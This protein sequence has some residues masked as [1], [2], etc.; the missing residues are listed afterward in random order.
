LGDLAQPLLLLSP[1]QR[2]TSTMS[3]TLD[4]ATEDRI[5]RELARGSYREPAEV[6]SRALD[7]L[8]ANREELDN[9]RIALLVRIE[10]SFAQ[11]DRGETYSS[12][13]ARA[14]LAAR[15]AVRAS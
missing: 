8:E 13:E 2:Y 1:S 15:R 14:E 4:S 5:Q 10:E 7:L 11:A 9:R 3:L 12:E 6:I